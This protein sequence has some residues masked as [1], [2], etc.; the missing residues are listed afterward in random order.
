[1]VGKSGLVLMGVKM[2]APRCGLF[3]GQLLG[4]GECERDPVYFWVLMIPGQQ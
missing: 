3:V 4:R 2:N 1:M